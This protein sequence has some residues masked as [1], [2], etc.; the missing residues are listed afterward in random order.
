MSVRVRKE[1]CTLGP[2]VVR[3]TFKVSFDVTEFR[4]LAMQPFELQAQP[5]FLYSFATVSLHSL[6]Y[7]SQRFGTDITGKQ[8]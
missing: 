8:W 1:P 7:N 6:K 5:S 4:T 3:I 2:E